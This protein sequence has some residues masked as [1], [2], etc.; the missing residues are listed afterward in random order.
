MASNYWFLDR[1]H[2]QSGP[3]GDDEFV[4]LIAQGVITRETQI[5]TSGMSEWR[6][7]GDVAGIAALFGPP[8][9]PPG[10]GRGTTS[11]PPTSALPTGMAG[12]L[13]TGPL[14][15][16]IPVWGLFGRSLLVLI[17]GLLVIPSPWT[18]TMFYKWLAERVSL[19][20]GERLTFA[21][22]PG[23]IWY[24]FVAWAVSLWIGELKHGEL[25]SVLISWIVPVLILKWFCEK[26]GTAD[27]SLRLSFVGGILPYIGWNILLTLSFITII[28]WA[29]V[30]K[31]MAQW[32]CRNVRG[33]AA[34]EFN[35]TGLEIL[36]RTLVTVLL[37]IL[38]IPIPWVMRWYTNW[39]ISQV[40]V[41]RPEAAL[42]PS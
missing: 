31:L 35:G 39:F 3:V 11:V 28:G 38:I 6:M 34:F 25:I 41:V 32:I 5:W 13:S 1:D 26:V 17:G 21:G 20:N 12:A 36:W 2:K 16:E 14:R 9:P 24:V 4:R 29:W 7:A 30:M 37:S 22:Q 42:A 23:D 40:S 10:S 8:G 19:P 27:G 15:P 18:G 33:S